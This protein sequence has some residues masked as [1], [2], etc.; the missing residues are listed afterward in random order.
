M[1]GRGGVQIAR[2]GELAAPIGLI[3][4]AANYPLARLAASGLLAHIVRDFGDGFH[5]AQ[6]TGFEQC[7]EAVQ[8]G[9]GIDK[10][11]HDGRAVEVDA[12][13]AR[14]GVGGD[15]A[16]DGENAAAADG[17]GAGQRLSL[18][19]R[20]DARVFND[21]IGGR[22]RCQAREEQPRQGYNRQHG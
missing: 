15:I 8:V 10:A 19:E 14:A 18:V 12:R 13:G 9:V 16:A 17:Q 21:Q 22:R 6:I 11:G 1:A 7:A 3:P 4:I 5:M 2:E 20:V